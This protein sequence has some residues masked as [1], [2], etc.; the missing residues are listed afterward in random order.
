MKLLLVVNCVFQFELD[1]LEPV[2]LDLL[3]NILVRDIFIQYGL[4]AGL[5]FDD[6]LLHGLDGFPELALESH[7]LIHGIVGNLGV[8]LIA[9][10]GNRYKCG[11]C[12]H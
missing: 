9:L 3:N 8:Q 1:S 10:H 4:V 11:I 5:M 7:D 6:G 2:W 12:S